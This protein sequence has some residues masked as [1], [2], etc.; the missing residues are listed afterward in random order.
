LSSPHAIEG[1]RA[2]K[3]QYRLFCRSKGDARTIG[4]SAMSPFR[5][6][7]DIQTMTEYIGAGSVVKELFVRNNV[8]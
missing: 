2:S 5:I 3:R 4:T 6:M 7:L 1:E 8:E